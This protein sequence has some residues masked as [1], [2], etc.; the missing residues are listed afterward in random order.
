MACLVC[1]SDG[2]EFFCTAIDRVRKLPEPVWQIRRC[3]RCGFGWTFP[4]PSEDETSSF[5]PPEYLGDV[6]RTLDDFLSGRLRGTRSWRGS[7]EKVE[8][9]ERHINRGSILDVGCGDGKFLWA[10][11]PGRWKATGVDNLPETLS[12]VRSR[13]PSLDLIEGDIN[14]GLLQEAGYDA[15]T[16]WHV[17]E[18]LPNPRRILRRASELLRPGGWLFVSLPRFDSLQA[19]LFHRYWYAFDDVPRHLYHFSR[20]S[21]DRILIEAGFMVRDHLLFSPLVNFHSLKHSLL[22]WS[23]ERLRSRIPYYLLKPLLYPF[24]LLER[25][26]DSYGILTTIAQKPLSFPRC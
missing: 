9:V 19:R 15:L 12:R 8:L 3:V 13:M 7:T 21:L 16:F 17:L 18:H 2:G 26:T 10:L 6:D 22:S 1:G 24:I 5:Y 20:S 23:S 4:I 25:A 11:D 14:S